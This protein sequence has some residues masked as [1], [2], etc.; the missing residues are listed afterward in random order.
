MKMN[1]SLPYTQGILFGIYSALNKTS[2]MFK[3]YMHIYVQV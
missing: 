3:A 1:I 2:A